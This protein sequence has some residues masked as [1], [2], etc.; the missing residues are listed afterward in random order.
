[1]LKLL[2]TFAQPYKFPPDMASLR[3]L[4]T[5]ELLC[6]IFMALLSEDGDDGEELPTHLPS[7]APVLLTHV[8]HKWRLVALAYPR[9]WS[10][11]LLP[12]KTSMFMEK[13]GLVRPFA[14]LIEWLK[15]SSRNPFTLKVTIDSDVNPEPCPCHYAK[16]SLFDYIL[17]RNSGR[18]ENLNL[19]IDAGQ[20]MHFHQCLPVLDFSELRTLSTHTSSYRLRVPLA[21]CH[22]PKLEE[23]SLSATDA[24]KDAFCVDRNISPSLRAL[25]L[26]LMTLEF[27][28]TLQPTNVTSVH[29]SDVA[30]RKADFAR[31]PVF[32]PLLEDLKIFF[33][34]IE[35]KDEELDDFVVLENLRSFTANCHYCFPVQN[36]T[37]PKLRFLAIE[38]EDW[39]ED[40]WTTFPDVL[41]F[42]ERSTPPLEVFHNN[43][44]VMDGEAFVEFL[45]LVPTLRELKIVNAPTTIDIL[46]ALAFPVQ[47]EPSD[48]PSLRCPKLRSLE[49]NLVLITDES[50]DDEKSMEIE[51]LSSLLTK[52]SEGNGF[53]EELTYPWT[54]SKW[55]GDKW[56]LVSSSCQFQ[57]VDVYDS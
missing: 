53:F 19:E 10:R 17:I 36:V 34:L 27:D 9:L 47:Q 49:C 54:S 52:R 13:N 4:N 6:L 2:L 57:G 26:R 55:S 7:K 31:F 35:D 23:L 5:P 41:A 28:R 20:F 32:F 12:L 33:H 21:V 24:S 1:M 44:L 48:T 38:N 25:K 29:L 30:I 56:D 18:F 51:V 43:G 39:E 46:K 22:A 8:C 42:I 14:L 11:L 37:V 40:E 3:V 45:D 50:P 16:I 15:R